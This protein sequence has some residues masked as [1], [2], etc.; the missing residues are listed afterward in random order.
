MK[1]TCLLV[2]GLRAFLVAASSASL[3]GQTF[4]LSGTASGKWGDGSNWVGG[5]A[6]SSN[7]SYNIEFQS[8]SGNPTIELT[9][10]S[11]TAGINRS[12]NNLTYIG[13]NASTQ[14]GGLGELFLF[15]NISNVASGPGQTISAKV[16]LNSNSHDISWVSD[17]LNITGVIRN[18]G[19]TATG[20]EKLG[21]GRLVLSA[22]NTF[23]GTALATQGVM[24]V[25]N[26]YALQNATVDTGSQGDQ[27]I[28]LRSIDFF[29]EDEGVT[30]ITRFGALQGAD[31]LQVTNNTVD[32]TSGFRSLDVGQNNASTEYSGGI[33]GNGNIIKS[34]TGRWNLTGTNLYTGTT[35][36][37]GGNLAVNG[38][39]ASGAVSVLSGAK[40]SGN[41]TVG[42]LTTIQS[43]GTH[44]VGNSVGLQ[45]FETG[46]TYNTGS[47]F[48]WELTSKVSS[49][50]GG[51]LPGEGTPT[52]GTGVRGTDFDAV[53]LTGSG[54]T[55]IQSGAIFKIVLGEAFD[56]IGSAFWDTR[57][58]W[59][60]F[61]TPGTQTGVFDTF[62]IWDTSGQIT[63]ASVK[64]GYFSFAWGTDSLG[65]E[66]GNLIW[67]P[68]PEPGN[69]LVGLILGA[70]LLKRRRKLAM[71]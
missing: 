58:V 67:T 57:Q 52:V 62:Q 59:E 29:D 46:V 5:V 53:D 6:P 12:I 22:A 44:A 1:K 32:G 27:S 61:N 14:L 51:L 41:G 9:N 65:A 26:W 31:D 50:S 21:A 18:S 49:K 16:A 2:N 4:T 56:R 34:G 45:T 71:A 30:L 68:I 23:T 19:S 64:P 70:G 38:S 20:F 24:Q 55:T 54:S 43:G 63:A 11:G 33:F 35:T 66:S 7:S 17:T 15:G 37:S 40:L 10:L 60:V 28:V 39:T 8:T 3:S 25:D 69:A 48:E 42:G 36:V 13:T 47:I